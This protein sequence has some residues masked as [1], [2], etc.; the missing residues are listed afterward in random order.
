M[1]SRAWERRNAL[2]RAKGYRSYYDYRRHGY[3]RSET[4]LSGPELRQA[5][6]HASLADL[7]R[8]VRSGR[9]AIL[10]Q[11]PEGEQDEA[12][13]YSQ[14]TITAQLANGDQRTFTLRGHQLDSDSLK[15]LR[16]AISGAGVDIYASP[17]LD[18][19]GIHPM[20]DVE[21]QD[22]LDY[23]DDEEAVA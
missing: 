3:G 14:A 4:P 21:E 15:S 13:R 22:W 18:I 8:L 2:A 1:A 17:S 6:G 10:I 9:V 19:L 7:E 16:T 23:D 5:R 11:A 20:D 12:G